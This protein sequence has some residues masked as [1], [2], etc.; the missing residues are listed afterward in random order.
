MKSLNY[1]ISDA[2]LRPALALAKE[3]SPL[4]GDHFILG[5]E[6]NL[7]KSL[8]GCEQLRCQLEG[9]DGIGKYRT[10]DGNTKEAYLP[11]C[12][13][14][15]EA[16][17][18]EFEIL[19]AN[20]IA[21]GRRIPTEMPDDMRQRYIKAVATLRNAELELELVRLF[22]HK[23][24]EEQTQIHDSHILRHGCVGIGKIAPT[25]GYPQGRLIEIDGQTVEPNKDGIMCITDSRSTFNEMKCCD[26]LDYIVKPWKNKCK[27]N[28]EPPIPDWPD[29]VPKPKVAL[30]EREIED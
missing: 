28:F 17:P 7:L 1:N 18:A 10:T 25:P 20:A 21:S 2:E 23:H 12:R 11:L 6:K 22:I 16:I 29:C 9:I 15:V 27:P 19:K 26:Y 3:Q 13:Q 5:G 24:K 8:E 30:K 14:A 4:L